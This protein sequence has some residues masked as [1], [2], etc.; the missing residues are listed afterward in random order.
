MAGIATSQVDFVIN[1]NIIAQQVQR[2]PSVNLSLLS[3][4][5]VLGPD[6]K[7]AGVLPLNNLWTTFTS[8]GIRDDYLCKCL[9][10]CGRCWNVV[11][12]WVRVKLH[13]SSQTRGIDHWKAFTVDDIFIAP[14]SNPAF[15]EMRSKTYQFGSQLAN[16]VCIWGIAVILHFNV[17]ASIFQECAESGKLN[18]WGSTTDLGQCYLISGKQQVRPKP[19]FPGSTR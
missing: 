19:G 12:C 8:V 2:D 18:T 1:I 15:V 4:R 11:M 3:F 6:E 14:K 7:C 9:Y 5:P 17:S 16:K 13:K 10:R